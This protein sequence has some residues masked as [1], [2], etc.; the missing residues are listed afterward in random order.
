MSSSEF[1]PPPLS[2]RKARYVDVFRKGG[3]LPSLIPEEINLPQTPTSDHSFQYLRP[4]TER[5]QLDTTNISSMVENFVEDVEKVNGGEISESNSHPLGS[6]YLARPN[7]NETSLSHLLSRRNTFAAF[8]RNQLNTNNNAL[9]VDS[10]HTPAVETLKPSPLRITTPISESM[11]TIFTNYAETNS[12][13]FAEL[14]ITKPTHSTTPIITI[15]KITSPTNPSSPPKPASDQTTPALSASSND[16]EKSEYLGF[17][18]TATVKPYRR[19]TGEILFTSIGPYRV[20]KTVGTGAFSQVKLALDSRN[21]EKVALKLISKQMV[22][23]SA[24]VQLSVTREIELMRS[25]DHPHII[26]LFDDFET[27][28]QVV[29]V[30]E[31]IDGGELFDL[32]TEHYSD[33]RTAEVKRI[34]R[35]LVQAVQY[36]HGNLI[37]HRDL[38]L[39]NVL[40]DSATRSVKLADFG[41]ARRFEP[42]EMLSTRCGSEEYTSPE[43]I[44]GENYDPK[45]SDTW[46][47]GVILFSLLTSE[48]PFLVEKGQTPRHMY[49]KI[50]RADFKFPKNLRYPKDS[51]PDGFEGD[52]NPDGPVV[53]ESAKSLVRMILVSNPKR[54]AAIEDILKHEWLTTTIEEE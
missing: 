46:A 4:I 38:K 43:I 34:F 47:L 27:R 25:L 1:P 2:R 16:S 33:L 32:I 26:K 14:D 28:E 13:V 48:M 39:E 8:K 42:G 6:N 54:R 24:R 31:Y 23:N 21:D 15:D 5:A 18:D 9:P 7:S 50:A 30:L 45:K 29:L 36:L 20:I 3:G 40:I 41:L 35:E 44:K 22:N 49:H 51:K 17:P 37:C 10:H 12:P 19:S 52:V 11:G 53:G